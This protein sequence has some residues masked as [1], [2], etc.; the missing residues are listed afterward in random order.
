MALICEVSIKTS[1]RDRSI[2]QMYEVTPSLSSRANHPAVLGGRGFVLS[3][4]HELHLPGAD[5]HA[6][7][8]EILRT[9]DVE[10]RELENHHALEAM[11]DARNANPIRLAILTSSAATVLLQA[12]NQSNTLRV[13]DWVFSLSSCPETQQA[14]SNLY[15]NSFRQSQTEKSECSVQPTKDCGVVPISSLLREPPAGF[16][17]AL[18]MQSQW[19]YLIRALQQHLISK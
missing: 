14:E 8:V 9:E 2:Y 3:E 19:L 18:L 5:A 1:R 13:W 12:C 6:A 4:N 15:T 11:D 7:Y 10:H 17:S 16:A